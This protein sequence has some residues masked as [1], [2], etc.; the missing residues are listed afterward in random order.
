MALTAE[1][2]NDLET[3][4]EQYLA[5][6]YQYDVAYYV[7]V[8]LPTDRLANFVAKQSELKQHN[9]LL[10]ALGIRY[11]RDKRWDDA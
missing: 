4:L 1:D 8:L 10:Y 11:M 7:D 3:A 6:N 2:Q 5:V 9:Q